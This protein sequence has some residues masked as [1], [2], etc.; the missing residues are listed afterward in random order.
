MLSSLRFARDAGPSCT[1]P[2]WLPSPQCAYLAVHWRSVTWWPASHNTS[3][4][5]MLERPAIGECS[6]LHLAA[7]LD[8]CGA[9]R[10]LSLSETN[11]T[12]LPAPRTTKA[13]ARAFFSLLGTT[14][15]RSPGVRLLQL[16]S[17]QNLAI[18]TPSPRS[19]LHRKRNIFGLVPARRVHPS[20]GYQTF[21][22]AFHA[23]W[24][25]PA[26]QR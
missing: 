16:S 11:L 6:H 26:R 2:T 5:C 8:P 12:S 15:A 14:L 13:A 3:A 9:D 10:P 4:V 21:A 19:Q 20:H 18:K 24:R 25:D 17:P 23:L 22:R 7:T 1:A